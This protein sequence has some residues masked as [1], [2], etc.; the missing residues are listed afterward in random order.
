[1]DWKKP[2]AKLILGLFV[3]CLSLD[4]F[5]VIG[6]QIAPDAVGRTMCSLRPFVLFGRLLFPSG[7][8]QYLDVVCTGFPNDAAISL[9]A[10][11]F[12][13]S[14]VSLGLITAIVMLAATS[15]LPLRQGSLPDSSSSPAATKTSESSKAARWARV[16]VFLVLPAVFVWRSL[17]RTSPGDFQ[18]SIPW[19]AHEDLLLFGGFICGVLAWLAFSDLVLLPVLRRWFPDKN[20]MRTR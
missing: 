13:V 7:W 12:K 18:G 17:A 14:L 20:W 8:S 4:I 19:K 5:T 3:L 6:E 11:L 9:M 15:T 2:G 1:M 16:L 10:F